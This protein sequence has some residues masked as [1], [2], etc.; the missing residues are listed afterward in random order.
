MDAFLH[1][2]TQSGRKVL[3]DG[4]FVE[5]LYAATV[6]VENGISTWFAKPGECTVTDVLRYYDQDNSNT[7]VLVLSPSGT[8]LNPPSSYDRTEPSNIWVS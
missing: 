7:M 3:S 5:S 6:G 2:L 1:S 8:I 4:N